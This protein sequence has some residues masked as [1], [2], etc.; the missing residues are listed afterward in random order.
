MMKSEEPKIIHIQEHYKASNLKTL[1]AF[2]SVIWFNFN[3]NSNIDLMV[4][5]QVKDLFK[6]KDFCFELKAKP[7]TLKYRTI[8]LKFI[9]LG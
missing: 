2:C 7:G 3:E 9:I 6:Y 8:W 4:D 1:F 5:L